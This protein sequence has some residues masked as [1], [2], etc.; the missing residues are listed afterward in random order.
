METTRKKYKPRAKK[1]SMSS[2]VSVRI[3]DKEKEDI[4]VVMK[5]LNIKRYSDFMRIALQM[6]QPD[7]SYSQVQ[8]S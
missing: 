5:N 8:I 4:D 7:M 2:V 3:T 6:V 1:A